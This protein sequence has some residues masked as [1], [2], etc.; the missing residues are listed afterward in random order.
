MKRFAK[1]ISVFVVLLLLAQPA[2]ANPLMFAPVQVSPTMITTSIVAKDLCQPKNTLREISRSHPI[3]YDWADRLV[4]VAQNGATIATYS[5][6]ALNRRVSKTASAGTTNYVYNYNQLI[7]E[8]AP[9]GH[10]AYVYG[11][12]LDNP[13][14]MEDPSSND[15]Y[16]LKDRQY[17]IIGLTNSS[18][19][20]VE[21]YI[22]NSFGLI[23]I[24]DGNNA[25]LTTSAIGNSFGY[26]GHLYDPESGLWHYRNRMY[27][28]QLGRFLQRDPKGYVDGYNL[29][30]F[31]H[32]NPLRYL[33]A[34]GFT[35]M[36][37]AATHAV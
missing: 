15:Y 17:N 2:F 22:Y 35:A 37:Y 25:P 28:P 7:E 30:A 29:Y 31:V 3:T 12:Y 11:T 20:I 34:M 6:D 32:N 18:G 36:S 24:F 10:K 23:S 27:S 33:D 19:T 4:T 13:I 14:L 8:Y 5:Y 16:Y 21:N 1:A 9:S 26:Q